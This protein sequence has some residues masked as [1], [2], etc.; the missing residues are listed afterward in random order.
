MLSA[1]A[2]GL[3]MDAAYKTL[4]WGWF[5]LLLDGLP[6]EPESELKDRKAA[7]YVEYSVVEAIPEKIRTE[8]LAAVV[9][10]SGNRQVNGGTHKMMRRWSDW[11]QRYRLLPIFECTDRA[12]LCP[13]RAL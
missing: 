2:A 4:E 7:K 13:N 5:Q 12:Y 11:Y 9:L 6:V 8:K 3:D 1:N 10:P